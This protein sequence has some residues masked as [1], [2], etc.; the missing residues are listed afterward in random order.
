GDRC[1]LSFNEKIPRLT[2]RSCGEFP[3]I[4]QP[5]LRATSCWSRDSHRSLTLLLICHPKPVQ[6]ARFSA[7]SL[8]QN[9]YS[10]RC[11][12]W[13]TAAGGRP[14]RVERLSPCPLPPPLPPENPFPHSAP[15]ATR[16]AAAPP[17]HSLG[18]I[19]S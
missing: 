7:T 8:S 9:S 13:G 19:P 14:F 15:P 12:A 2:G 1:K 17:A 10:S 6:L 16:P 11:R 4:G 3:G 5:C 18:A